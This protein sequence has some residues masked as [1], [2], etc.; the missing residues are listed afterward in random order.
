MFV[1]KTDKYSRLTKYKA[2]L[3]IRRNQQHECDLPTKT[4][5]LATTSFQIL[6]ALI[7]KFDLETL[8]IDAVNTF[9]YI[10]LDELV[11]IRNSSGF[12]APRTVLRFNK[13]LYSLKRSPLLW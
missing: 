6:L 1:Y 4:T 2:R 10:D 13:A 9:V 3:I 8:Q 12:P 11:Y 5:I 7:T